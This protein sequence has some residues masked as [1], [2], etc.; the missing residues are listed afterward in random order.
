MDTLE[1]ETPDD[2]QTDDARSGVERL[3]RWMLPA[4]LILGIVGDVLLRTFPLGLNAAL[5]VTAALGCAAGLR[6]WRR[7]RFSAWGLIFL[8][9]SWA[10]ALCISWRDSTYLTWL[11]VWC[12]LASAAVTSGTVGGFLPACASFLEYTVT[13]VFG[14]ARIVGGGWRTVKAADPRQWRVDSLRQPWV[15]G[16]VR[17]VL[18]SIPILVV[19]GVL[20]VSADRAF[21]E[22]IS[23]VFSF[24]LEALRQHTVAFVISAWLA[25]GVLTALVLGIE[26]PSPDEEAFRELQVGGVEAGVVMGAVDALFLAFVVV[27]FQYFFGGAGRIEAVAELTYAE[28][29]RHG[30][31]E[32][33][34]VTALTLLLQ[35][36]FHWLMRYRS[37]RARAV[38]RGL[39]VVQLLLVAVIMVSALMRMHLYVEAY[40]LTQLRFY[41]TAFMVWIGFSLMWFAATALWGYAKRFMVGMVVSGMLLV[42]VFHAV[43]PTGII[44]S[45]NLD[46]VDEG[47]RFD[48]G[49]AL[50][51]G[52][53]AVPEL[54]AGLDRLRKTDAA[55]VR[56]GLGRHW[57][58]LRDADWRTWNWSRARAARTLEGLFGEGGPGSVAP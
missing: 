31:F 39:S 50:S 1:A 35:Y 32:L 15:S 12:L 55:M 56:N 9:L 44:V 10:F 8:A 19:F 36:G 29:A 54:V 18:I 34:A 4:A 21:G 28:Y 41:S 48:A 46:R 33:C 47:K 2:A 16:L 27:Q 57:A 13:L 25:G 11:A 53:D 26:R 37:G 45:W 5:W 20:L 49:Y 43:N 30:F 23:R 7:E 14:A 52:A 51:L 24:D 58:R 22:L 42:L 3:G 6:Y 38:C 17:G 40:G